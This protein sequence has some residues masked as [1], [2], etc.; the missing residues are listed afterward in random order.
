MSAAMLI[1]SFV[2]LLAL[3]LWRPHARTMLQRR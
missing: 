2:V 1:F 3:Y